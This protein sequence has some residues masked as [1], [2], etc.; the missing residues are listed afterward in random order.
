MGWKDLLEQDIVRNLLQYL[1]D[2][3]VYRKDE[4]S[5]NINFF[6]QTLDYFL[7]RFLTQLS[8]AAGNSNILTCEDEQVYNRH[9]ILAKYL[10]VPTQTF[11]DYKNIVKG[12][13]TCYIKGPTVASI[14]EGVEMFAAREPEIME[15]Y[16]RY[17]GVEAY[18]YLFKVSIPIEEEEYELRNAIK[19][20]LHHIKP[21]HTI[22]VVRWGLPYEALD[23]I[24]PFPI[25]D[26][27]ATPGH[28]E[29]YLNWTNPLSSDLEGVIIVR[30]TDDLP[31]NIYDGV[32][33]YN[34]L[35]TSA[36]DS[37]LH[38][39]TKYYY[40]IWAYDENANLSTPSYAICTPEEID[41]TSPGEVRYLTVTPDDGKIWLNWLNPLTPD[42][43][44]VKIQRREDHYPTTPGDGTTVYQGSGQQ[45][46]DTGL[47]NGT[48]YYY[49]VFTVDNN[50]NWS[51][52]ESVSATPE[53]IDDT[54]P[55][56]VFNFLAIP[57]DEMVFLTWIN[58]TN[59]DFLETEIRRS[60]VDYPAT[61]DDG[62]AVT[63]SIGAGK[64]D[65][66]EDINLTNGI[67]YYYTAFSKDIAG[68]YSIAHVSAMPIP[69]G[70]WILGESVIGASTIL[71][72][73]VPPLEE[74]V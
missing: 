11:E 61:P 53:A 65:Y 71:G 26:F 38:N 45:A 55:S 48:L 18:K 9:G 40:T 6:Y 10:K 51:S 47:V 2:G 27:T 63:I 49:T 44:E 50:S 7:Q 67:L 46:E 36:I 29:V 37:N 72:V 25:V 35:G 1:P 43:K 41:K 21:A 22:C 23:F 33:I 15:G 8:L 5:T 34:G 66:K 62:D 69:T 19:T 59:H 12:L 14:K 39:G 52:G 54:L 32:E 74:I 30:S 42:F 58:P 57:G 4:R 73:Y 24:L 31:A 20:F 68:N 64:L 13:Y 70:T 17:P 56:S 16:K 3:P 60:A 28:R